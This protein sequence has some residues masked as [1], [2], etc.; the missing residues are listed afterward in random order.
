MLALHFNG[1]GLWPQSR[2]MSTAATNLNGV[3]YGEGGG[4]TAV[5]RLAGVTFDWTNHGN[6][7]SSIPFASRTNSSN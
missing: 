3:Y 6:F 2:L 7:Q 4:Q 5:N 1:G